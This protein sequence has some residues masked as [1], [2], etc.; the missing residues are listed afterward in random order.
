[1]HFSLHNLLVVLS[2]AIWFS[3][4][5]ILSNTITSVRDWALGEEDT[6]DK[7]V[8]DLVIFGVL[9]VIAIVLTKCVLQQ[10]FTTAHDRAFA[11]HVFGRTTGFSTYE[12]EK[13]EVRVTE[14]AYN[15]PRGG[16]VGSFLRSGRGRL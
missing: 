5:F 14:P 11:D 2:A 4:G 13:V 10:D 15:H 6:Q 7:A 8:A 3:W 12:A 16:T 1:M 9:T